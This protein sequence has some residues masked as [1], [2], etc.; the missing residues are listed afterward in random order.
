MTIDEIKEELGARNEQALLADGLDKALIGIGERF[1]TGA[2]AVYDVDKVVE[3]LVDRDGMTAE[4]AQEHF[5]HNI[6]GSG[7]DGAPIF[8]E[9]KREAFG[10]N[11]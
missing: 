6:L 10:V 11:G 5:E 7:L 2:L 9:I 8:I 1:G 3:L 4:E